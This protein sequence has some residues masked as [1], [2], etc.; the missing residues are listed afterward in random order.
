LQAIARFASIA[1]LEGVA[2]SL[3]EIPGSTRTILPVSFPL[4]D[5]AQRRDN[6]QAYL[7]QS[8]I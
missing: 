2:P 4:P 1:I 7:S 6:W 8:G 3:S 5:F